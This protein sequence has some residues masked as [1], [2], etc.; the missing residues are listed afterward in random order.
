MEEFIKNMSSNPPVIIGAVIGIIGTL[1]GIII[2]GFFNV[3]ISNTKRKNE[4]RL[5]ALD[6][7][8]DAHQRAYVICNLLRANLPR[9]DNSNNNNC[10]KARNKFTI[11]WNEYCLYLGPNSR[12]S[13][14]KL[15]NIYDDF[16]FIEIKEKPGLLF[17]DAFKKAT[18]A[19]VQ[20]VELPSLGN[21][22]FIDKDYTSK[23]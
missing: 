1:S 19:I 20:D 18:T 22:E 4:L 14:K 7:R 23:T 11:Y 21:H 8:L 5:A 12:K 15:I 6:K 2:T 9:R 16:I 17:I 10:I 13:I 3:Y